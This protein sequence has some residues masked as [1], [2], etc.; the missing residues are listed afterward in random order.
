L[1][2]YNLFSWLKAKF[3]FHCFSIKAIIFE[4]TSLM[5]VQ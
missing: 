4:Q 3:S 1:T 2:F 5:C